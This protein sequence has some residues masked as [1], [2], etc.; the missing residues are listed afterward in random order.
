MSFHKSFKR[1]LFPPGLLDDLFQQIDVIGECFASGSGERTGGERTIILVRL[2]YGDVTRLLQ[3]TDM[4]GDVSVR[5]VERVTQFRERKLRRSSEH[6]HDT[7][8]PFLVDHPIKLEKRFGVH[9]SFCS[10]P[11]AKR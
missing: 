5:H 6:G 2:A 7:Q 9:N 3:R 1:K 11:V 10:S 4:R 8:P